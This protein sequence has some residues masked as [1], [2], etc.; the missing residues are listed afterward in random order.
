MPQNAQ[1]TRGDIY[2]FTDLE[3]ARSFRDHC[4]RPAFIFHGPDDGYVV[5]IGRAAQELIHDGHEAIK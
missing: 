5:A 3:N 1:L 2:E 4:V